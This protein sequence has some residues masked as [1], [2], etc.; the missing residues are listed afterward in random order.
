[1]ISALNLAYH[2]REDRSWFKVR[3]IALGLSL[4][5]SILLLTGLF[6]GLVG[7][8][9]L[10]WFGTG[11]RMDPVVVLAWKAIQWAAAILFVTMS[12][13][14]VYHFGANL[15]QRRHW[16]W[17]TPGGAFGAFVWLAASFGFRMYLHFFNNYSATYGSLGAVMILLAWLYVTGLAYLIGGEI[18]AEIE[19][20]GK[21]ESS[22]QN[23]Q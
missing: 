13:A 15:Q 23:P 21:R 18:N 6:A 1:M 2:V 19:R 17:V 11:L 7:S 14:L 22:E 16:Q 9:F 8:H 4:L 3:A 20:A 10:R 5:I 12:C